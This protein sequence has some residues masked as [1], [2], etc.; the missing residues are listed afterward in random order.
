MTR[1]SLFP[2]SIRAPI[3]LSQAS[4]LKPESVYIIFPHLVQFVDFEFFDLETIVLS[5]IKQ[6]NWL[7]PP[8]YD[9]DLLPQSQPKSCPLIS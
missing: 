9:R 5:S 3:N 2:G 8:G 4:L 6:S 7:F 1:A